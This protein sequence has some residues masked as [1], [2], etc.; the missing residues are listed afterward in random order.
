[1]TGTSAAEMT[2]ISDVCEERTDKSVGNVTVVSV[3]GDVSITTCVGNAG[4][5]TSGG[6]ATVGIPVLT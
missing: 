2:A 3:I 5:G 6:D 1:M 4:M